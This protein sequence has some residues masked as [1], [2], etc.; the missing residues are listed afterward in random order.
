V[1]LGDVSANRTTTS[2]LLACL[3]LLWTAACGEPVEEGLVSL[4]RPGPVDRDLED[5]REE[6]VLRILVTTDSTSY[7]LYRGTPMGYDYGLLK[8]FANQHELALEVVLVRDREELVERLDRGDGDVGAARLIPDYEAE[9]GPAWTLALYE[10]PPTLVQREGPPLG[11]PPVVEETLE[12][13][14]PGDRGFDPERIGMEPREI[15]AR[16]L[17]RRSEVA[18]ETVAVPD[19]SEYSERALE[20]FDVEGD[21]VEV[22]EVEDEASYEALIRQVARGEVRLAAS[23]R[24]LAALKESYF[25]NVVVYP[26]LGPTHPTA[27]AVRRNAPDLLAALNAFLAQDGELPRYDELYAKYFVDRQ[28]YREREE[29]EYLT[30]VTGRLSAYDDLLRQQ[31]AQLG[32]DWRL[33]ASQ[34]YQESRFDPKAKSWAGA[35]G[36]LQLMPATAK[37]FEV[38]NRFDPEENVEGAV[39]FIDWQLDYWEDKIADPEERLKFVLASYN[40]GHGHVLD[41]RRLTEKHGHDPD[42][43]ND[44]AYWMIQLSKKKYYTDPVVKYGYCRGLEPVAYVERILDRWAH[45]RNFVEG[46]VEVA[47]QSAHDAPRSAR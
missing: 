9:S 17:R 18:G 12:E 43:W 19:R 2:V 38:A 20:L 16:L 1:A 11:T 8:R 23:P 31:A 14:P 21:E 37:Q 44:V 28:G 29:S 36:L 33:L 39:R 35:G 25:T 15:R 42:V 30:S 40:A 4:V 22:V 24:N 10:T 13:G 3:L 7:F 32:W 46:G 5:L 6:G 41:A 27:W 34:T 26:T 45:Y 47:L